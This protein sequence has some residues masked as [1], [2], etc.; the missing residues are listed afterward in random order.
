MK[1]PA[2]SGTCGME[3]TYLAGD[4]WMAYVD[5]DYGLWRGEGEGVEV[6][7]KMLLGHIP[8]DKIASYENTAT[9]LGR[10]YGMMY[11]DAAEFLN[12]SGVKCVIK[13]L[14]PVIHEALPL[15]E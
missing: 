14:P 15:P 8:S 13:N 10:P 9:V 2:A 5:D 3:K 6:P 1:A 11:P 4:G 12:A 7:L